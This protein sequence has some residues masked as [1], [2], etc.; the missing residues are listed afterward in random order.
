MV[1]TALFVEGGLAVGI[2]A[3][4]VTWSRRRFIPRPE[5]IAEVTE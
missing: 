5:A 2:A 4:L 1:F 3:L